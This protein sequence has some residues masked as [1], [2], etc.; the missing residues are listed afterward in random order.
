MSSTSAFRNQR[1]TFRN[2]SPPY[3]EKTLDRPRWIVPSRK[4][5]R[6]VLC[7]TPGEFRA[8]VGLETAS[9]TRVS[10]YEE[11]P[12]LVRLRDGPDWYRYVPSFRVDLATGPVMLELSHMG[13]PRTAVQTL[14]SALA[15]AHFARNGIPLVHL[16]HAKVLAQPRRGA[17]A[18]LFR[19]LA[20]LPTA[21]E[22][23]QTRDVLAHTPA[24]IARVEVAADVRRERLMS[25]V[26]RGELEL[27]G[28][29]PYSLESLLALPGQADVR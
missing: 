17:A 1:P 8:V 5:G 4:N 23:M 28:L 20:G 16:A 27:V 14:V 2:P 10:S 12:E 13:Q 9:P 3:A 6:Q 26:R 29:P 22:V 21:A 15:T 19:Y 11:R 7:W 18:L 24:S 25:M